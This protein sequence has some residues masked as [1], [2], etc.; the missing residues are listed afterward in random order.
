ML[1]EREG[2]IFIKAIIDPDTLKVDVRS[3]FKERYFENLLSLEIELNGPIAAR[4]YEK[5]GIS[6]RVHL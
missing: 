5:Y 1:Q 2:K 3:L 6:I 4:L